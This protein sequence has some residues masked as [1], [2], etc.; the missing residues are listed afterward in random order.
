MKKILSILAFMLMASMTNAP[1]APSCPDENHP[2]AIDLGLPSGTKWA[3]CNI[4]ASHPEESGD[5]YA[6]GETTNK[7]DFS[8]ATYIHCDGSY[9][10]CHD[11]GA[12]IAGMSY[13]VA[14]EKWGD[15]WQM[16]SSEQINELI[17]NC[18]SKWKTLNS[19][20]GRYYTGPNGNT[21]FLP[22]AGYRWGGNLYRINGNG[23]YWSSSQGPSQSDYAY[24]LNVSSKSSLL[25]EYYRYYGHVIRPVWCGE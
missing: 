11:L 22:A 16:P 23:Y 21:I 9:D 13:D 18:T 7:N 14:H 6:W 25:D 3:C 5:F 19:L 15:K 2:H 20:K 24:L 8:W 12:D 4:G 1:M 17:K 10:T